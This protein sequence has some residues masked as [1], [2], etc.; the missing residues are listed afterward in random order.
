MPAKNDHKEIKIEVRFPDSGFPKCM[1]FNRFRIHREKDFLLLHFG[2]DSGTEGVLD[3]YSCIMSYYAR[4][5]N[6]LSLI[7]YLNRCPRPKEKPPVWNK[8]FPVER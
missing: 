1:Y 4:E 3:H 7:D 5:Q 8:S 6:K 2:M